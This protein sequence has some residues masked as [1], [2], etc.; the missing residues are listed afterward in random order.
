MRAKDRALYAAA[1][2]LC[3][4]PLG[5]ALLRVGA[6]NL[7]GQDRWITLTGLWAMRLLVLAF[8]ITPLARA[9]HQ[10][11]MIRLRRVIGLTA[12][13]Y[14]SLHIVSYVVV[15]EVWRA[16]WI[17]IT[18]FYLLLG[19]VAFLL[20]IPMAATSSNGAA[21]RIGGDAWKRLHR[22]IYVIAPLAAAHFL[23]ASN[24]VPAEAVIEAALILV[25]LGARLAHRRAVA[26]RR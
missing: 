5:L 8:A 2:A 25:L 3:L 9:L 6:W 10:R 4:L 20:L 12:F 26:R 15:D 17:V 24:S 14:T 21:R 16:P 7:S 23:L 18:R 11:W 22:A 13:A 1:T 19:T